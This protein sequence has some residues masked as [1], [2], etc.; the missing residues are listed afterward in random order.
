MKFDFCVVINKEEVL[1][2]IDERTSIDY[3]IKIKFS[4]PDSD[5]RI[6]KSG[7]RYL[8]LDWMEYFKKMAA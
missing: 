7:Q 4:Q 8:F 6:L 3:A 2:S 5:V 1:Y